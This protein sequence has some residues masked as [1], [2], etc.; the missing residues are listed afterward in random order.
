MSN[1]KDT[2]PADQSAPDEASRTEHDRLLEDARSFA[3]KRRRNTETDETEEAVDDVQEASE[4]SFPASD[5]PS[6]TPATSIGP[7]RHEK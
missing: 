3:R 2:Q 6:F 1:R 5:A 4:E 7:K